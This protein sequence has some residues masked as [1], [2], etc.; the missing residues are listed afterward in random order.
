MERRSHLGQTTS[1]VAIDGGKPLFSLFRVLE[2]NIPNPFH[3]NPEL[4]SLSDE[5]DRLHLVMFDYCELANHR[6]LPL[7]DLQRKR[8]CALESL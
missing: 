1:Y 2:G 6:K 3:A 5:H 7:N 8:K 4:Y